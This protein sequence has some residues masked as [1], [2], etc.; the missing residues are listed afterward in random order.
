[1]LFLGKTPQ[2][3]AIILMA[4]IPANSGD[5]PVAASTTNV[6]LFTRWFR[7]SWGRLWESKVTR[8]YVFGYAGKSCLRCVWQRSVLAELAHARGWDSRSL[9]LDICK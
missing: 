7:R 5:R 8:S 1:M 4:L 6:R 2:V 3:L 9:L